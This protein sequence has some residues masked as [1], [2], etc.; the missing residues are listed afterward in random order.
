MRLFM[1]VFC[2]LL[3]ALIL[4][5]CGGSS[6]SPPATGSGG[7]TILVTKTVVPTAGTWN[8]WPACSD[9]DWSGLLALS[10][11]MHGWKGPN[12]EVL[13]Q[14]YFDRFKYG[15]DP[16]QEPPCGP[17]TL[18]DISSAC[19]DQ[20]QDHAGAT[21]GVL[22]DT[23]NAFAWND[24]DPTFDA[25]AYTAKSIAAGHPV[26]ARLKS[27]SYALITGAQWEV[28]KIDAAYVRVDKITVATL[29]SLTDKT[30]IAIPADGGGDAPEIAMFDAGSDH[31]Y[32]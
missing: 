10:M 24:G 9:L 18:L 2:V 22:L 4:A 17:A 11:Q 14:D 1:T 12:G 13:N 19:P 20:F 6:S 32:F 16:G 27:G 30:T 3:G 25:G 23:A 31:F 15:T 28:K 8:A 5:G 26:L 7:T 21:I 29:P